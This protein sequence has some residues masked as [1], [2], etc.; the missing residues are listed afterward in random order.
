MQ[1][2]E[3]PPLRPQIWGRPL[4]KPGFVWK[5]GLPVLINVTQISMRKRNGTS[6]CPP[7]GMSCSSAQRKR[8]PSRASPVVSKLRRVSS[9]VIKERAKINRDCSTLFPQD[10]WMVHLPRMASI[11]EEPGFVTPDAP[12]HQFGAQREYHSALFL[13]AELL[14][15]RCAPVSEGAKACKEAKGNKK[16]TTENRQANTQAKQTPN[17]KTKTRTPQPRRIP[18]QQ[19]RH[20]RRVRRSPHRTGETRGSMRP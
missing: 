9:F 14:S 5:S 1:D 16:Q 3:T 18:L 12:Q 6:I 17:P 10:S 8:L 2:W 4:G 15:V 11:F 13:L 20:V 7:H 19:V